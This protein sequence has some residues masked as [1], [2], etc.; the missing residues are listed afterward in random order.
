M[1]RVIS[2]KHLL[3]Y[4]SAERHEL[5]RNMADLNEKF[6]LGMDQSELTALVENAGEPGY[7]ARQLMEAVYRQRVTSIDEISTLPQQFRLSL[8]QSGV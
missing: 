8:A 3:V 6:L 5:M 1:R 2:E 4:W 7:R